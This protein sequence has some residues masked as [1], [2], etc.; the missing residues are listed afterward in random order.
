MWW[1]IPFIPALQR[2]RLADFCGFKASLVY[3]MSSSIAMS[4]SQRDHD[5]KKNE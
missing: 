2:Q 4:Q 3:I 1:G 5:W